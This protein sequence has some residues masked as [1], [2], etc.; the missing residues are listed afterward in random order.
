MW[1]L[2]HD[3]SPDRHPGQPARSRTLRAQSPGVTSPRA[4]RGRI[5]GFIRAAI[6]VVVIGAFLPAAAA[7]VTWTGNGADDNWSTGANWGGTAPVAGDALVFAGTTR[8]TPNNDL[9]ASTS[10]SSI[11]FNAGAGGLHPRL[12]MLSRWPVI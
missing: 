3:Q 4:V 9:T 1:S 8:L 11:T 10:F 12:A 2:R 7:T 5:H 6:L